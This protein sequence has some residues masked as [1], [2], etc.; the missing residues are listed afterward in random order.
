MNRNFAI[1]NAVFFEFCGETID[2]RE[3]LLVRFQPGQVPA[4]EML[5]KIQGSNQQIE[6]VF[7]QVTDFKISGRDEG[8]PPESGAMLGIAGFSDGNPDTL[9]PELYLE[10]TSEMNYITFFMN[11]RSSIS[12]KAN[13]ASMRRL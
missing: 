7:H 4:V 11:D 5:W 6:V 2:A 9:E 12:I 10:P 13:A 8:Y 3:L 1:T